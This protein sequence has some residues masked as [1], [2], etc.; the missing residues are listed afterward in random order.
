MTRTTSVRACASPPAAGAGRR[1]QQGR[2]G[3]GGG[4]PAALTRREQLAACAL[5]SAA[6][7]A[8]PCGA[9]RADGGEQQSS[10]YCRSFRQRFETSIAAS[11]RD[12]CFTYPE[13]WKEE[14]V[15]LN[16]GK[17]Y[18]VDTRF[19]ARREGQLSVAVLP[20]GDRESI[21]D[22]G[23]PLEVLENFSELIGAFWYENGFGEPLD[24]D[25]VLS[26][27]AVTRK[28]NRRQLGGRGEAVYYFYELKPHTLISATVSDGQLY[29]MNASSSARQWSGLAAGD[30]RSTGD[31]ERSLR[32]IVNSFE[33]P[34]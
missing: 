22:A 15:S 17:L 27:R 16:D 25:T 28:G 14:I 5:A 8:F 18:G 26:A 12:Y 3:G 34:S 23:A 33:V 20:Y 2:G 11:T 30:G 7:A 6:A 13:G 29:V 31:V 4:A 10:S 24:E 1:A 9:A 32:A 21:A 19:G